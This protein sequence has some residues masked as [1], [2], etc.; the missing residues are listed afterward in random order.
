LSCS[1]RV[2][3]P[4]RDAILK[5]VL[6]VDKIQSKVAE[7]AED[8]GSVPD[9]LKIAAMD[10]PSRSKL[11]RGRGD[12]TINSGMGVWLQRN[13]VPW[14]SGPVSKPAT[15]TVDMIRRQAGL[16]MERQ[17]AEVLQHCSEESLVP[18]V[19]AVAS[20]LLE[21]ALQKRSTRQSTANGEVPLAA[22]GVLPYVSRGQ[23]GGKHQRLCVAP[24][25]VGCPERHALSSLDSRAF[26]Q[27]LAFQRTSFEQVCDLMRSVEALPCERFCQV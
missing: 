14:T 6:V 7:H 11:L 12:R 15:T 26:P 4:C 8:A 17:K 10:T 3:K 25:C 20:Q 9:L 16:L 2:R 22:E 21:G 1:Q 13:L 27:A 24:S 5:E 23:R 18:L 19:Q